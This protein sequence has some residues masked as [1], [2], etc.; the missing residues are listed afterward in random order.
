MVTEAQ[1]APYAPIDAV[2]GVIRRLRDRGLPEVLTAQ[3]LPQLGVAEGNAPRTLVAL[4]F[5]GLVDDDGRRTEEFNRLGQAS[6]EQYPEQLAQIVRAAYAPVFTIV[7]PAV[8][9]DIAVADAF[10]QY[11]PLSQRARMIALFNGL[12]REAGIIPGGPLQRRERARRGAA[13]AA[14]ARVAQPRRQRRRPQAEAAPPPPRHREEAEH[15]HLEDGGPV[16]YRPLA[17][18]MQQ[19]PKDGKWSQARRDRWMRAFEANVDL[20]IEIVP[21]GG[22]A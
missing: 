21:E 11:Q 17:A 7:D 9:S 16:D 13:A 20:L 22:V 6:T 5:L 8:D 3:N 2:V 19:L 18:L 10:R 4:R 1:N 12:C 15:E 14:P